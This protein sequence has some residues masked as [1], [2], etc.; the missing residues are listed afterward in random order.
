MKS[1][2]LYKFEYKNKH[3]IRWSTEGF[4]FTAAPIIIAGTKI[5]DCQLGKD[6]KVIA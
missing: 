4:N 1:A 2:N 6:R 5:F 3:K